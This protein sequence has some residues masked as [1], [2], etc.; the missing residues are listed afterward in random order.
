MFRNYN[1]DK[2]MHFWD[3]KPLHEVEESE[4][5]PRF[6]TYDDE[7]LEDGE[8]RER[9]AKEVGNLMGTLDEN[10]RKVLELRFYEDYSLWEVGKNLGIGKQ[11]NVLRIQES[12]LR[13]LRGRMNR[14]SLHIKI[15]RELE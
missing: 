1:A 13:K 5:D 10:E 8:S 14:Q 6:V 12:A 2:R 11:Q 4:M 7:K 15:V 3:A 9:L